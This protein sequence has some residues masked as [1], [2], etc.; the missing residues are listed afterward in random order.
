VDCATPGAGRLDGSNALAMAELP[1]PSGSADRIYQALVVGL[2]VEADT[3]NR[4]AEIQAE[5]VMEADAARD[6]AAGVNLDEEMTN[7]DAYAAAARVMN[8]VDE[9][10][11]ILINRTAV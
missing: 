5:V 9:A 10:L 3:A 8:A 7:L 4:R 1:N 6:S 2:G 11:E